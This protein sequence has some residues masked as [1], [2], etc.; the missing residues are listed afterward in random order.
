[1]QVTVENTGTLGRRMTVDLPSGEVDSAV[2]ERLK[3]LS[4]TVRINGFRPGKVPFKVVRKRF[5]PQ[6]RAEVMG[7]LIN[8]SMQQAL[9]EHD[10][11]LAGTPEVQSVDEK[12]PASGEDAADGDT[13]FRYTATFEVYPEF[14]PAFDDSIKVT[15]PVAEIGEA[16][17]DEMVESL[18][19]QR[20]EH[21]VV[22][23]AAADGDQV[24]IDFVGRI[25]G[26]PFDGGRAEKAPLVLGSGAMIPGFEDQLMGVS[27]GDD[28]TVTVDFPAD[29]QSDALAGRTAEFDIHVHEVR[30][31]KQP[32]LDA[33][34]V[35]SFGIEDGEVESLK[36][37]IRKN[38]QRE[39]DQRIDRE[40][41]GQVMDGLVAANPIEVPAALV[42]E[43]IG[44]QRE[45]LLGQMPPGTDASFLSDDLF[46][47]QAEKRVRL[48]LVLGEIVRRH[49]IRA[50]APA[51]REE[52]ERIAS[53]YQDPQE[54]IDHYYGDAELL[55]NV[56]GLVLERTVTD[57]VL[58][59][60]S[61]TD[62]PRSFKEIMN[63]PKP[64]VPDASGDGAQASSEGAGDGADGGAD[65]GAV[66]GAGDGDVA[67]AAADPTLEGGDAPASPG[68]TP[69][70]DTSNATSSQ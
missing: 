61:V 49:E 70:A 66:D 63:P 5:E 21:V 58:A 68:G 29:Y 6:V 15:R 27:A 51:V 7:S 10:I 42:G 20:T 40:V 33:E 41:R 9:R 50:E 69:S 59:A 43:E 35:K 55:R 30:E 57:R 1:M 32:E 53:S 36:A 34:L 23:R 25:D 44:R 13:A 8:K 16:D 2:D 22:E 28:K 39:L 12:A 14:E 62:E 67:D 45:Q 3:S 60:A 24:V 56:E 37:D 48:G 52:I 17:V 31:P 11:K 19:T 65:D 54:V 64:Q 26:E 46:R 38:M 4:R 18:R 47:E